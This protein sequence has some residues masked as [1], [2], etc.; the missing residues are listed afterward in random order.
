[1]RFNRRVAIGLQA[2]EIR[3]SPPNKTGLSPMDSTPPPPPAPPAAVVNKSL[4]SYVTVQHRTSPAPTPPSV[5]S[6]AANAGGGVPL[7]SPSPK[8]KWSFYLPLFGLYSIFTRENLLPI[9]GQSAPSPA[10]SAPPMGGASTNADK[11]RE[12][13]RQREQERRKREAVSCDIHRCVTNS[14]LIDRCV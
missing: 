14:L 10:S 6:P 3:P 5:P 2:D 11:E 7:P 1:M 9:I 8:G 13:Q 12:R 4:H